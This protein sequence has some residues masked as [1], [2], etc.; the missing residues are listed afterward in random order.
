MKMSLRLKLMLFTFCI[1]LLVGGTISLY[2][3]YQVQQRILVTFR[4]DC[5]DMAAMIAEVVV[6]DVYGLNLYALRQRLA[7][8]QVNPHIRYTY[9]TDV[10]G[11]VLADGTRAN[12]RRDQRLAD[13]FSADMLRT[14]AWISRIEDGMLKMGGP[15]QLPDGSRIGY[16]HVGFS[17]ERPHQIVR[18]T[19]RASLVL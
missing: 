14:G 16:L 15:L 13:P 5:Q 10:D 1:V 11:V 12:P 4:R 3:T 2:V 8:T 17:L 7:D 9:V 18:E 19:T 6:N